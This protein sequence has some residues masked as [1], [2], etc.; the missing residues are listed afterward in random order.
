MEKR[1]ASDE[2]DSLLAESES[3]QALPTGQKEVLQN[4]DPG[5]HVIIIIVVFKIFFVVVIVFVV[6]VVEHSKAR[7]VLFIFFLDT[8]VKNEIRQ[9]NWQRPFIAAKVKK[10]Y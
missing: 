3:I 7:R 6:V 4:F 5:M 1:R 9:K 8:A 10:M 2:N